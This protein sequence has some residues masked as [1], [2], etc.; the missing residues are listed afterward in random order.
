MYN[1]IGLTSSR[2]TGTSG[3]VVRNLSAL[4][5]KK[6]KPNE[7]YSSSASANAPVSSLG[8]RLDSSIV[9][10]Q[11]KRQIELKVLHLQDELENQGLSPSDPT[12]QDQLD[13]YRSKLYSDLHLESQTPSLPSSTDTHQILLAKQKQDKQFAEALGIDGSYIEGTAFD[14]DL[15]EL[16]KQEKRLQYEERLL[17][18]KQAEL[19]NLSN[20]KKRHS[21]LESSSDSSDQSYSP[22]RQK[23]YKKR[24]TDSSS[25][26]SSETGSDSSSDSHSHSSHKPY[27]K[28]KSRVRH[29][30]DIPSDYRDKSRV[31]RTEDSPSDYRDKSRDRYRG[32]DHL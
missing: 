12:F 25:M 26:Q 30:E 19:A 7:P 1:G 14:K 31:R 3:Y 4:P 32:K 27:N 29:R 18:Q 2:G 8:R 15:L 11:A 10:H 6:Y 13:Q 20:T 9:E 21:S 28:D 23:K 24:L 16:K 17:L 5:T 22:K